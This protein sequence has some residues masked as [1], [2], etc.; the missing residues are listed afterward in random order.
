[1]TAEGRITPRWP[2]LPAYILG[3]T[4]EIWE[5]RG[6]ATLEASYAPGIVV[7]SAGG[8]SVGDGR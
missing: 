8:V 3:V 4:R 1:M 7:R 2:D 6:I 5:D